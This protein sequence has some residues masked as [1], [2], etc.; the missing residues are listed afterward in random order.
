VRVPNLQTSTVIDLSGQVLNW[1][2]STNTETFTFPGLRR[3][4]GT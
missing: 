2:G 3:R 4:T 1:D